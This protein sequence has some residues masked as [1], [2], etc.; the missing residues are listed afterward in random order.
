MP[1]K[2]V[3][4]PKIAAQAANR[5]VISLSSIVTIDKFTCMAVATVSRI[6]SID[7]FTRAMAQQF[8]LMLAALAHAKESQLAAITHRKHIVAADKDVDLADIQTVRAVL[9]W[10]NQMQDREDRGAV[11][12][13]FGALTTLARVLD[14][15]RVQT[16][17]V[18]HH[19]KF[20]GG[21]VL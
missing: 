15:K 1:A 12:F 7:E 17:F 13:N 21:G 16:E 14:R 20:F 18:C 11:F 9:R 6:A 8:G 4:T 3:E 19:F 5:L 10:F 2:V